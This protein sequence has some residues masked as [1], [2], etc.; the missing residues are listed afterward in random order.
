M[1]KMMIALLLAGGVSSAALAEHN[2]TPP[3]GYDNYGQ[4]RSALAMAQNDVRMNPE[5]YSDIAAEQIE[6]AECEE[7]VD[8][9]Y[10]IIFT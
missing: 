4:C 3:E 2:P 8:G 7:D 5:E 10:R 9:S 6:T 1:R